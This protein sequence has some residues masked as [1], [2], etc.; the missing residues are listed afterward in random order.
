MYLDQ[1]FCL[2]ARN[3]FDD[4]SIVVSFPVPRDTLRSHVWEV[5]KR[6]KGYVSAIYT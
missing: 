2:A 1:G 4:V 5:S 6:L 3:R